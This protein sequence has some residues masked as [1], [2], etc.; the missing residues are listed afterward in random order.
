VPLGVLSWNRNVIVKS[1][2]TS[3][4]LTREWSRRQIQSLGKRLHI[5]EWNDFDELPSSDDAVVMADPESP[6]V[7]PMQ[8]KIVEMV[9]RPAPFLPFALKTL[10]SWMV[11]VGQIMFFSV[12]LYFLL[13][14]GPGFWSHVISR[15]P[16]LWR[17]TLSSLG[18][19]GRN[20]L[21]S[22][23]V[24]H[25]LSAVSA[26]LLALPIF[27]I[28]VGV[29]HFVLLAML[30]GFCQFIPLLGSA[31]FV[32]ALTFYFFA[33]GRLGEAWECV[34]MAFPIIVAL[35]DFFVRPYL[36]SRFGKVHSITMLAGFIAGFEVFGVLGFILGPLSLDLIVQFTKQVL[37]TQSDQST[38]VLE[39]HDLSSGE[40]SLDRSS[41]D[42]PIDSKATS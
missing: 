9:S 8:E 1:A 26:F 30:A 38:S 33:M 37:N 15:S 23:C 11:L 17:S 25:G 35:P 7:Q 5:Q 36:A 22:I 20:V 42:S 24:V 34:F 12:A 31:T 32:G 3:Y 6:Q 13:L 19:R 29:K 39:T 14:H 40:I 27:W 41:V 10:H 2:E 18:E 28:I 4:A 21:M 16:I